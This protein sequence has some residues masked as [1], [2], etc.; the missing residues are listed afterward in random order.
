MQQLEYKIIRNLE[1]NV[2]VLKMKRLFLNSYL[3]MANISLDESL[4]SRL[5]LYYNW[6][7]IRTAT[8]WL[9]KHGCELEKAERSIN[10]VKNNFIAIFTNGSIKVK[11]I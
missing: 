6:T 11:H 10:L 5:D 7:A 4:Q 8:F 1:D 9:L 3:Q 2:F